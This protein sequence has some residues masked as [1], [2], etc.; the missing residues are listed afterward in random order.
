MFCFFWSIILQNIC[1]C[2][3]NIIKNDRIIGNISL[4]LFSKKS[5]CS[6]FQLILIL[7]AYT[8]D[9][10][11]LWSYGSWIYNYLCNQCL[12][13]LMLW[14][15]ISI[16]A[17]CTILCDEVCQWLATGRWFSPGS[18]V[19]SINKTG[20]CDITEILLT[21]SKVNFNTEKT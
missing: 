12:L 10:E 17:R 3:S 9:I 18:L 4:S 8:H 6:S 15:W 5:F 21:S 11:G 14:V 7:S 13:P 16:R 20:R 19:S 2:L 1:S